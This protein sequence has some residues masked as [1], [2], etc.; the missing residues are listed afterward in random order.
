M[1]EAPNGDI[2]SSH[3]KATLLTTFTA[4]LV[5]IAQQIK[6]DDYRK[7]AV[8]LAPFLAL[9]LIVIFKTIY[10]RDKCKNL[11]KIHESWILLLE[12]ELQKTETSPARKK[13]ITKEIIGY[14][15]E[16][17]KLQKYSVKIQ[18]L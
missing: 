16:I 10:E 5:S 12:A 9:L 4:V 15:A 18:Y 2:V 8:P 1:S 7:I 17:K 13:E 11:I 14:K 3:P 6:D